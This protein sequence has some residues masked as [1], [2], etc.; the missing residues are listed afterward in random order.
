MFR[1]N[2]MEPDK[3]TL[4]EW[5]DHVLTQSFTKK[6]IKSRFKAMYISFQP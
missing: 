2:H 3:I 4:V 5:V 6:N 1:N